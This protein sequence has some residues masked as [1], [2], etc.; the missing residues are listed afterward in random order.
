MEASV[1]VVMITFNGDPF[2][3]QQLN[4][5]LQQKY[6][7]EVLIYDDNSSSDFKR[8]LRE[9]IEAHD[10]ITLHENE[11]TLGVIRNIKKGLY[12]NQSEE[13]IA[14]ADQDDVWLED[15][16][17]ISLKEMLELEKGRRDIPTLIY[18]DM[19]II[20]ENDQVLPGTFWKNRRQDIFEHNFQT[21]LIVNLITG[22]ASLMNQELAGYA[23]DIPEDLEIYHDAWLGMVAYTMGKAKNI[24][25]TLSAHRS[26]EKSLTFNQKRS[27]SLLKR[28]CNNIIQLSGKEE[29]LKH[30]FKFIECFLDTYEL[31]LETSQRLKL[32]EFLSLKGKGYIAQKK[33][34]WAA[35]KKLEKP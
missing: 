17:E 29:P 30:Q 15:K 21:N 25:R 24:K 23:K 2:F 28:V 20:D 22:S 34:I 3:Q 4:S 33:Y 13:Y 1:T 5:I 7:K 35:Q 10:I 11:E 12:E 27:N 32:Q 18:H 6:L 26:H 9:S 8:T 31:R 14:L 16:L 19:K